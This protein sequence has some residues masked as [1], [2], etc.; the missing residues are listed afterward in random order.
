MVEAVWA[1]KNTPPFFLFH[2]KELI[3]S[4]LKYSKIYGTKKGEMRERS[5]FVRGKILLPHHNNSITRCFS[6]GF[7]PIP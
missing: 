1:G 2:R 3:I 5:S 4:N 7:N 6:T